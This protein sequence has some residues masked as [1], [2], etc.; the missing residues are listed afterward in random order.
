MNQTVATDL[1][2]SVG[3]CQSEGDARF[4]IVQTDC[5]QLIAFNSSHKGNMID[6]LLTGV[7]QKGG[8]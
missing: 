7:D 8:T 1:F 2:W 5:L 3:G 4:I 6:F